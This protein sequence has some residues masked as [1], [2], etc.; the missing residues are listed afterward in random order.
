MYDRPDPEEQL[1]AVAAFLRDQV[2]P[3]LDG[4]MAFH[5]RVC[6]N[7]LDIVGRQWQQAPVAEVDELVR[8]RELLGMDGSLPALNRELCVRIADGRIDASTPGLAAHLWRVTLDK[9]AVDQPR[10]EGFVRATQSRG[11]A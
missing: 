2:L 1:T 9:L 7:M 8:L 11:S 4:Q 3:K 5:A 10:Y 6:A